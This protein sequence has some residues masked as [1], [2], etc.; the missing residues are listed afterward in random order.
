GQ[1]SNEGDSLVTFAS[2]LRSMARG[3]E[4]TERSL[5]AAVPRSRRSV[6][7]LAVDILEDRTVPAITLTGVPNWVEQ[8]PGPI[9]NNPNVA[10]MEAQGKPVSGAVEAIA[11]HPTDANTL[12]IGT[13]SGG[14]W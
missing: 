10:G 3:N 7:R 2:W 14:I 8:G 5:R 11:A 6:R 1:Y 13:A 4:R 12:F 9:Q